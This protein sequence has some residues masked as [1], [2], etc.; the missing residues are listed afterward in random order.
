MNSRITRL[1]KNGS[2]QAVRIPKAFEFAD[3]AT[4]VR[5]YREDNRLIIEPLPRRV[6]L[7]VL[8]KSWQPLPDSDFLP[9]LQDPPC[10]NHGVFD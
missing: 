8:L 4:E 3:A 6:G 2:N 7:D 10:P 9:D 5:I 1:F